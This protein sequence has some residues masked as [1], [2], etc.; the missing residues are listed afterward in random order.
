MIY[1]LHPDVDHFLTFAINADEAERVL[2]KD[3]TFH[4]DESPVS[5]ASS[6]RPM[7]I[8]FYASSYKKVSALPDISQANGRLFLNE[9][10]FD[11]LC[12]E[13]E[14]CG[15]FLP[16]TY[17]SGKG[18]LLNIL[19]T[20][21]DALDAKLCTKN[22]WGDITW[23]AFQEDKLPPQTLFR[24]EFDDYLSV[25]CRDS[26]RDQYESARLTGLIFSE[27]LSPTPP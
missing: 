7:E 2:G 6:W 10:A 19:T 3:T 18:Y 27:D 26:F 17:K 20:A 12:Q 21:D 11:A 14:S 13:L 4:F 1:S 15:E 5:Y 23:M 24:T 25:F 8:E 9:K 16:V 22:K